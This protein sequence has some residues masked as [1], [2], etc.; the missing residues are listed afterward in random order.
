MIIN[1]LIDFKEQAVVA[2]YNLV[3]G[4]IHTLSQEIINSKDNNFTSWS[5]W[6]YMRFFPTLDLLTMLFSEKLRCGL[7]EMQVTMQFPNVQEYEGDFER[8]LPVSEI[9]NVLAYII[10]RHIIVI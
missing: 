10:V 5:K 2:P 8:W 3:C 4:D 6:K 1:W 9:D 7:K